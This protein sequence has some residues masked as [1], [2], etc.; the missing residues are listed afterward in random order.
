[1][2]VVLE[3]M[4]SPNPAALK[5]WTLP[6]PN[7]NLISLLPETIPLEANSNSV[8]NLEAKNGL[9]APDPFLFMGD[10]KAC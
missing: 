3:F 1:M 2:T 8:E 6:T 10:P 4:T 5:V 9:F 7:K